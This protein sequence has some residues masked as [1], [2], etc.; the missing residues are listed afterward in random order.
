MDH[1]VHR[2]AMGA[3][4]PPLL[5]LPRL[6]V[7]LHLLGKFLHAAAA[8]KPAAAGAAAVAAEHFAV[9]AAAAV[10]SVSSVEYSWPLTF[11]QTRPTWIWPFV[12]FPRPESTKRPTC[13]VC[14]GPTVESRLETK[15]C[16]RQKTNRPRSNATRWRHGPKGIRGK[17]VEDAKRCSR[18]WQ[19][20]E[21]R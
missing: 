19:G 10:E 5:L 8:A 15:P 17:E 3:R 12:S 11:E 7:V 18:D 16:S 4:A 13:D 9:V 20:C 2:D 21:S 14:L 6:L 1:S